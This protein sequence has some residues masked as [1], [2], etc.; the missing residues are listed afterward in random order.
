[1]NASLMTLEVCVMA[2]GVLLLLADFW[3]PVERKKFLAYAAIAA[4]GGLL[5][6]SFGGDG[7]CS[8]FGTAFNGSFVE[9]ALALFFKRFFLVAAILVLF[10]SVEFSDRLA[11]GVSEYHSLIVFALSGMLFAASSNDFVMLFV[12]IELITIT[13]YVL[14]SFQRGRLVSLE[15]GVKYLI[16]GALSS[17]FLVFGIALIWGTTGK[18][19]FTELAAVA[20]QFADNK[21]FLFGVLFVL[22]GLGF[23]IAAFPFQIWT[24]DVYQ[25][26]PTP[27]TAFL[28]V[29]SKAAGF[30]LL[31][32]VLFTAVPSVTAHWAD[33]LIVISGITILYGNLCA[34]P[35]RNLKRLLGYSS[36]A[37]AGYLLL[38]VAALSASGA[39]ALLY[40][41][42]GYLFT[43]VAAFMVI[44]L[45]LR[46][47]ETEDISGLAGLNRRSPLLAATMTLAMASLAGIPPLAGFFGKFL[48]LKAVI[49]QAQV[50][51]NH[52]YYCLAFTAL[53]GVV[54]SIYY[55]FGVVRAI[56]WSGNAPDL[57]PITLS[58]PAKF[59]I[60]VCIAGMFWLG[61]FPA[62]MLN[63]AN[64][65]AKTLGI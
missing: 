31:L 19:N 34:I 33:L 58:G 44:A 52:G 15:A 3:M 5:L 60:A 39:A 12:S 10:L 20:S 43:V 9:D 63:L 6:V 65:A 51:G 49:E 24:P 50:T 28:A 61:L 13:F 53:A 48:L 23:K 41:L 8:V 17:A 26:A 18:L 29:G 16:L 21:I 27:T 25:G 7:I 4:L 38:G 22:A 1:M 30:V 42:A 35:Q 62:T 45:V 59:S 11:A 2:L 46:H 47:L 57:S 37:H 36:I 32:R 64:E 56:Y 54:V 14:T 55:Y 40:Y